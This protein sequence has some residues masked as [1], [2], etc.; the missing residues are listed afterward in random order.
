MIRPLIVV[1]VLT[2]G[3]SA[4]QAGCEKDTDCKGD[5]ICEAGACVSPAPAAP[6]ASPATEVPAEAEA[7][8]AEATESE[9]APAEAEAAPAEAE[10]AP[11]EDAEATESAPAKAE[12]A[13][14]T[15]ASEEKPAPT[16]PKDWWKEAVRKAETPV[17][18]EIFNSMP[19][20]IKRKGNA[21]LVYHRAVP[22]VIPDIHTTTT[23][24]GGKGQVNVRF[25]GI[26]KVHSTTTME[27]VDEGTP[28]IAY[29]PVNCSRIEDIVTSGDEVSIIYDSA[30]KEWGGRAADTMAGYTRKVGKQYR[31]MCS[32]PILKNLAPRSAWLDPEEVKAVQKAAVDE[33]NRYC[34]RD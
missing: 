8:T 9:A 12:G 2:L 22:V 18:Q 30:I 3:S 25:L 19:R 33:L 27:M 20:P 7:E 24:W 14:A 15:E 34:G 28:G 17:L 5:R 23:R 11:A 4:A 21:K 31:S 1:A 6:P 32:F 26:S 10:A 13:E 29:C 16:N